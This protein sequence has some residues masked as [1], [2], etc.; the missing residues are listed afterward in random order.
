M[1]RLAAVAVVGLLVL[2]A[3][4]GIPSQPRPHAVPTDQVP[5]GLLAPPTTPPSPTTTPGLAVR[6]EVFLVNNDRLSPVIRNITAP[7]TPAQVL[8][9]LVAGPTP[10]EAAAGLRS[11]LGDQALPISVLPGPDAAVDLGA[12]FA[13]ISNQ[14]QILALA[15]VVY[16]LTAL[17]GV[18]GVRFTLD[19][20]P[21]EVPRADGTLTPGPLTRADYSAVAGP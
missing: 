10:Q 5:F 16:T 7:A 3:G 14:D 6:V 4:C 1:R 18:S 15:Q 9:S 20:K 11:A 19:H 12:G 2:V 13:Q 17:Q 21:I 8:K